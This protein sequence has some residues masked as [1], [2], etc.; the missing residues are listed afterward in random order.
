MEKL[1]VLG[2]YGPAHRLN[3]E[4]ESGYTLPP[5]VAEENT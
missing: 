3:R 2:G 1:T 5:R 4:G